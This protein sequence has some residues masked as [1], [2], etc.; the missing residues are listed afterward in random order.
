MLRRNNPIFRLSCREDFEEEAFEGGRSEEQTSGGN[1]EKGASGSDLDGKDSEDTGESHGEGSSAGEDTRGGARGAS[2]SPQPPRDPSPERRSTTQVRAVGT[3][4]PSLTRGDVEELLLDQRILFEM[5]LR[6]VKLEI[7]QHVT[8]EFT[9][10][11]EFL[12][13]LVARVGPRQRTASRVLYQKLSLHNFNQRSSLLIIPL[14]DITYMEDPR[15][16][17]CTSRTS[18]LTQE[19]CKMQEPQSPRM[20]SRT[21]MKRRTV[22]M[23]PMAMV[24]AMA[25]DSASSSTFKKIKIQRDDT[26]FDAYVIGKEDAP[27]LVVLQE[28]W[29][30]DFEIKNHAQKISQFEPG[31]KALIPD[32]YRGKVGLDVAE[33]Q[34]LMD[35][36]DW[37][38]A[39]KDIQASVNWLKAN[40]SKKVG[41]T[42][43]CM[44][45]ALA[46]ASSVLVPG[47]DAV[48]AFYGVPSPELADPLHAKAPV[49]AH[50]GELDNIVGFS[51]VKTGK[52]LEEKLKAS[53]VPHEVHIYPGASHAFMNKSPEGVQRRK[54]MGLTDEDD[55]AVELAWTHFRNWM[56][57][58]LSP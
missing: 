19:I 45:G 21:T 17:A 35:G 4:A 33:A 26:T 7:Q 36:L 48:V 9:S 57:R 39:V 14:S 54:N 16:H 58:F 25:S 42:G 3:S 20:T 53:G 28:W 49:Q 47:V 44:G 12:A 38:G 56:N 5:R 52:A 6:T 22:P 11:R 18:Q 37:Q 41:V 43:Y 30:V 27:G 55:V 24:R 15:S 32:L 13:T 34:H 23:R 1:E 40:G 31:Y 46:I 29:G 8:S 50:F 2:F 51:D 10:L